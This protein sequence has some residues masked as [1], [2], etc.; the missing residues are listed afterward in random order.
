M[1][2]GILIIGA[3]ESGADV[4]GGGLDDCSARPEFTLVFRVF[5]DQGSDAVLTDNPGFMYS[6]LTNSSDSTSEPMELSLT[7]GV[8][9]MASRMLFFTQVNPR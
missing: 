2:F 1:A 3:L 7:I 4:A 8:S 6:I 9:P 5:D